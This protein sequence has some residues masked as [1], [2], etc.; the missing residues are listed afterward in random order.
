MSILTRHQRWTVKPPPG[1]QINRGHSLA[2]GLVGAWLFNEGGGAVVRNLAGE[3]VSNGAATAPSWVQGPWGSSLLFNG[4]TAFITMGAEPKINNLGPVT[5]VFWALYDSGSLHYF[6]DKSDGNVAN[7]DWWIDLITGPLIQFKKELGTTNLDMRCTAPAAGVWFQCAVTWDGTLSSGS[8]KMYVNGR[9]QAVTETNPGSGTRADNTTSLQVMKS[10]VDSTFQA[11]Q[12]DHLLL[13]NRVLNPTEIAHLYTEPFA[14]MVSGSRFPRF[15]GLANLVLIAQQGSFALT[16]QSAGL[17]AGRKLTASQG[18]FA[19]TG[20]AANLLAGRAV[21]AQAGSFTLS[22]QSAILLGAR[23]I[24]ASRGSFVLSGQ[25]AGLFTSH[26]LVAQVG[27][28]SLSGQDARLDKGVI[29]TASRGSFALTGEDAILSVVRILTA[30]RGSFTL[31]GFPA[32]LTK[33]AA[34]MVLH[35]QCGLFVLT[36]FP[37]EMRVIG[38]PPPPPIPQNQVTLVDVPY[39]GFVSGKAEVKLE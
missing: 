37:A 11:G 34:E 22:G 19:L 36:G 18:S 38:P 12:M 1:A 10:K 21:Q 28:F 5:I 16:G 29:L 15:A 27:S 39:S 6:V 23:V 17:L 20:E 2:I 7:G 4:S 9:S 3:T 26:L 30:S 25:N 32:E 24:A 13:Y 33:A 8:T 14:M 31:T 35:A